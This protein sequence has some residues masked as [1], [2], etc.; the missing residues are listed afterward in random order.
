MIGRL[1]RWL[2]VYNACFSRSRGLLLV[3]LPLRPEKPRG[4][5]DTTMALTTTWLRPMLTL[6]FLSTFVFAAAEVGYAYSAADVKSGNALSS[7]S[8]KA[9]SNVMSRLEKQPKHSACTAKN[10]RVR[11]EWYVILRA[12]PNQLIANSTMSRKLTEP[13]VPSHRKRSRASSTPS[14]ASAPSPAYT[15]REQSPA[16]SPSTTTS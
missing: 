16:Q 5:I 9:Y 2:T 3:V 1:T 10:V 15:R 7:L 6:F 14:N 12:W 11:R 8:E 13:G 4:F